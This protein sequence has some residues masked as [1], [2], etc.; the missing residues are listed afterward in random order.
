VALIE[1]TEFVSVGRENSLSGD[2]KLIIFGFD[3]E[4]DDIIF[5]PQHHDLKVLSTVDFIPDFVASLPAS[6]GTGA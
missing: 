1:E 4:D 3:Q 5:H 2:P 6:E